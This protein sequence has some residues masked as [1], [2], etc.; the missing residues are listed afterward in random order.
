MMLKEYFDK[1]RIDPFTFAYNT[2]ISVT[3]IYRYLKG[4]K[5]HLKRAVKIEKAT[6]G[7]VTVEELRGSNDEPPRTK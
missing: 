1:H 3:A 4:F 2:D 5:P 7:L 6:G